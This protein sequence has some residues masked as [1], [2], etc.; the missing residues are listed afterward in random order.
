MSWW[1]S[2]RNSVVGKLLGYAVQKSV[3]PNTKWTDT[4]DDIEQTTAQA[5]AEK[6]TEKNKK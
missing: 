3:D 2:L 6:I 4:R 1:T 5:V